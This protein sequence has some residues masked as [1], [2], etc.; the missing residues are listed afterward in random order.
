[1]H[2]AAVCIRLEQTHWQ[3]ILRNDVLELEI[4]RLKKQR[5][6]VYGETQDVFPFHSVEVYPISRK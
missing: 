1:M 3:K 5:L 4:I 6:D 2:S